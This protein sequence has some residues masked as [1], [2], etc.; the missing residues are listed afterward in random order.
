MRRE[1]Q[2]S[3]NV[4][5]EDEPS[6]SLWPH[7]GKLNSQLPGVITFAYDLRFGRSIAHWKGIYKLYNFWLKKCIFMATIWPLISKKRRLGTQNGPEILGLEKLQ[8]N[9]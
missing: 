3:Q 9:N 8:K 4:T 2:K 1:P 5:L 6:L 7:G